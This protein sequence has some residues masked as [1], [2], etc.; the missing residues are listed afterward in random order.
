MKQA[1]YYVKPRRFTLKY[2]LRVKSMNVI[3]DQNQNPRSRDNNERNAS[4]RLREE[5]KIVTSS[6]INR[7]AHKAATNRIIFAR[8]AILPA[9]ERDI[10]DKF[11]TINKTMLCKIVMW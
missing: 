10:Y 2:K 11:L 8:R 4:C 5:K 6:L 7:L 1:A 9:S 3:Y